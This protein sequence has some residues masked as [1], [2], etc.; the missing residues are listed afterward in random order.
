[1]AEQRTNAKGETVELNES[2]Q[3]WEPVAA[4]AVEAVETK[5]VEEPEDV[6]AAVEVVEEPA[7]RRNPTRWDK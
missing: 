7:P 6:E 4:V 5:T 2:T 1:M 3:R